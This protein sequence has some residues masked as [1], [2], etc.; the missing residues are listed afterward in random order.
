VALIGGA[1]SA[2]LGELEAE[3]ILRARQSDADLVA[4]QAR[5]DRIL[6]SEQ[7]RFFDAMADDLEKTVKSFN[8]RMGLEGQDAVT[9]VHSGNQVQ[10]GRRA[11]PFFLRKVLHFERTNEVLVRT[12]IIEGYR[13]GEKEEKWYFDAKDGE[14][15][16]NHN[17]F[18][19]CADLL[20]EGIPD[21]FR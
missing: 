2:N 6:Y 9:F 4:R 7:P 3:R 15:K 8:L 20:F 10:V 13:K 18:A 14:L 17:N 19:Q 16:L 12:T 5:E 21:T 11:K 1:V